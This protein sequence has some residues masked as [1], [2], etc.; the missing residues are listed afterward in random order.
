MEMDNAT[1]ISNKHVNPPQLGTPPGYSQVVDVR[2]G[3]IIFIAGQTALDQI[4]DLV[5]K[6][7]FTTQAEQVF[8]NLSVALQSV[9]C[10]ASN[11]L[12][13]TVFLRNMDNLAAY[14]EA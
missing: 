8:R 6:N 9:G 13:L 10:T 4:G 11:L 3:R 1:N 14:R 7:D 5:G 2:A 12:K